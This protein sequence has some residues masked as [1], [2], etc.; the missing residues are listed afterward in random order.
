MANRFDW[1]TAREDGD[2]VLDVQ[3]PLAIYATETGHILLRADNTGL[4]EDEATIYILPQFVPQVVKA[5]QRVALEITNEESSLPL[6]GG[7]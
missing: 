5:L 4:Y 1:R 7:N 2:L 6:E 3:P